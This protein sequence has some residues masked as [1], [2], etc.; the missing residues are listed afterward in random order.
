[1]KLRNNN[2]EINKPRIYIFFLKK[3]IK[4]FL[5]TMNIKD[6]MLMDLAMIQWQMYQR[7]RAQHRIGSSKL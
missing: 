1:M 4:Q 7:Y 3:K 2:E 5:K 6:M